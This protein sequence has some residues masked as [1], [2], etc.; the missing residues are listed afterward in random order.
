MAQ[1]QR[2]PRKVREQMEE[3]EKLIKAGKAP[4]EPPA[5]GDPAP[6]DAMPA[7]APEAAKPAPAAAPAPEAAKPAPAPTS[8]SEA[9]LWRQRYMSLQGKYNAEVPQLRA[10]MEAMQRD[11]VEMRRA[12]SAPAAPDPADSEDLEN[13]GEDFINLVERRA[14]KIAQRLVET[15]F[16]ELRPQIEQVGRQVTETR[17]QTASER[18][19]AKL[20]QEVQDW[21]GVNQSAQFH[22]WLD[23][24]DPFSGVPRSQLLQNAFNQGDANRVTHIFKTYLQETAALAAP[25]PKAQTREPGRA[26]LAD[27]AA[28]GAARTAEPVA[29]EVQQPPTIS[30]Q[31]I[32]AFYADV[33][34]GEYKHRPEEQRRI[35]GLIFQATMAGTVT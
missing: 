34:K 28:P 5:E 21:K 11:L 10:Q 29:V 8:E 30:R 32:A 19:Y 4:V 35:E 23:R 20:D 14:T 33:T 17:Q 12:P 25:A 1:S 27:F 15:K 24:P 7:P 26:N 9:E 16:G 6:V 13:Y 31:E 18:I 2:V 3:A 22:N